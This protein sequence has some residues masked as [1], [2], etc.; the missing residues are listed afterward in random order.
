MSDEK[1]ELKALLEDHGIEVPHQWGVKKMQ[2]VL[3]EMTSTEP[4]GVSEGD[5]IE[6][7]SE[8]DE[9]LDI[10]HP[11]ASR[12][13][14]AP[15]HVEEKEAAEAAQR[16]K[17]L[18]AEL[19]AERR[20][21]VQRAPTLQEESEAVQGGDPNKMVSVR[22]TKKGQGRV[23]D[24]NLYHGRPGFYAESE[25]VDMSETAALSNQAKGYV[26]IQ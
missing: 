6:A 11:A 14:R 10:P 3:D 5:E 22:I 9:E 21:Q 20:A 8:D 2:S 24:G 25:I 17:E 12:A 16:E 7:D 26:E 1:E 4:A 15:T 23:Q 18:E 13:Q 19:E